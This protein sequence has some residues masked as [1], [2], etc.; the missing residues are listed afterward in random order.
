MGAHQRSHEVEL[1]DLMVTPS[2]RQVVAFIFSG[3][4]EHQHDP[5]ISGRIGVKDAS[6]EDA[7]DG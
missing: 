1:G 3:G 7:V 5:I 2:P 6:A 4:I